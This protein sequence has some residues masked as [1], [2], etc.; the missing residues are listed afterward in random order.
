MRS[1]LLRSQNV[2]GVLLNELKYVNSW[3]KIL[4]LIAYLYCG[5]NQDVF[6]TYLTQCDKILILFSEKLKQ[7]D[8][9]FHFEQ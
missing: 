8:H 5:N 6:K 3:T 4:G 2:S 7:C 1:K 9:L